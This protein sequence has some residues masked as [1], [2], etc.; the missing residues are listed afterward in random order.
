MSQIRENW[1]DIDGVVERVTE[2]G[3]DGTAMTVHLR[4]HAARPVAGFANLLADDVGDV[5][6]VRIRDADAAPFTASS[7]APVEGAAVSGRVRK[8]TADVCV[9]EEGSLHIV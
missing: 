8:V 1:S 3:G 4:V 2:A 9:A 7:T 5:I 6:A